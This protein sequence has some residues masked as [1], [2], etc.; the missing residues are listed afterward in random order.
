MKISES[1]VVFGAVV[2]LY[3]ADN[4]SNI[5]YQIVGQDEA[6]TSKEKI[7]YNSPVALALMGREEGD[8]VTVKAP[9]GDRNYEIQEITFN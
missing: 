5:T 9:G 3:D 6:Q 8:E 2:T 4:D 7:S 1:K